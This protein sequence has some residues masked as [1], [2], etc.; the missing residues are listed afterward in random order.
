MFDPTTVRR[1][2]LVAFAFSIACEAQVEGVPEGKL[3]LV[4]ESALG[5]EDVQ[6]VQAQLGAYAQAR[7]RGAHGRRAMLD[8]LID[9]E[10]LNQEAIAAGL[11]NDPRAHWA[12]V[13]EL[14][15]LHVSAELE[16]RLPR[17]EV[18]ADTAA[19]RAYYDAHPEDF[20]EPERRSLEGV[21]FD[22]LFEAEKALARCKVGDAE[23]G[24]FGDIVSTPLSRRND[25]EFPG[26]HALLFDG[27]LQ[28][29]DW[30]VHPVVTERQVIVGRVAQIDGGTLRPF[31]DPDVQ[32]ELVSQVRN[33][34]LDGLRAQILAELGERYPATS[35]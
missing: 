24:E 27:S 16:R 13:E 35:L 7:F 5:P 3:A 23:L 30:L 26:F 31:D 11:E 19:L 33:E 17:A 18:A 21:K 29:G 32:E 34:R 10:V 8:S 12:I 25:T 14:A 22:D 4:G 1:L 20:A 9:A 2:I 15:N 6:E 28:E